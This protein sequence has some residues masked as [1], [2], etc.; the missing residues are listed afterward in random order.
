M[1]E[2]GPR[3]SPYS[4]QACMGAQEGDSLYDLEEYPA[5]HQRTEKWNGDIAGKVPNLTAWCM[6]QGCKFLP[7]PPLCKRQKQN[8]VLKIACSRETISIE[9]GDGE[10]WERG[11]KGELVRSE[12]RLIK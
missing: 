12:T 4:F 7:S 6:G 3:R 1:D 2:S 11:E 5:F 8:C 10:R 9:E